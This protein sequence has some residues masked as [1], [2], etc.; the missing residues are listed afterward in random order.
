VPQEI[1]MKDQLMTEIRT[2][3]KRIG[4]AA[5]SR[6]PELVER[7]RI[8]RNEI[9]GTLAR[10]FDTWL[11]VNPE[12]KT[13]FVD[14]PTWRAR[15]REWKEKKRREA[16]SPIPGLP[17]EASPEASATPPAVLPV[18][19]VRELFG[20]PISIYTRANALSDGVLA[21]VTPSA[22]GLFKIPVAFSSAL[23]AIIEDLPAGQSG[24]APV[25]ERIREVL[26]AAIDVAR[27]NPEGPSPFTV[28]L[29]IGTS[30]GV[31]SLEL[32]VHCGPGDRGEPVVTIG[33]PSDF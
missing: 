32:F 18:D 6:V 23:W 21:D 12:G 16:T 29:L 27:R 2:L 17:P 7:L 22:A 26:R 25:Q 31:K 28:P 15:V 8:K 33:F 30:G 1:L 20:D 24:D 14:R 13:E 11:L 3:T 4:Q 5:R 19:P 9:A 10:D